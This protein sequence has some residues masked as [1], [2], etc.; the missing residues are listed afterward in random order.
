MAE[1]HKKYA[2]FEELVFENRNKAYGAYDLRKSYSGLLTKAFFIGVALFLAAIILP[3]VY[4]KATE[5]AKEDAGREVEVTLEDANLPEEPPKEEEKEEEIIEK[6]EEKL[7]SLEDL[8]P[9]A[10]TPPVATIQ[11]VVPEPKQ[12]AKNETP[13]P[14]KEDLEGKAISTKTQEGV[15]AIN[16]AP[17]QPKGVEGGR[18]NQE[19]QEGTKVVE[20][21]VDN[22][23]IH[24]AAD[25]EPKFLSG[26]IDGL[27]KM[28]QSNFDTEAVEGEG[29]LTTEVVFVVEPNGTISQVKASGKNSDFNREAERVIRSIRT[30]W[31]PA[32]KGGQKVRYRYRFPLKMRFE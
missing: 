12:D 10:D 20:K 16:N 31:E 8:A 15:A 11:N 28:V 30:K 13:P 25:K 14:P 1:E 9:P 17:A 27:R 2:D 18:G 21:P 6:V 4:M 22:K 29:I 19:K 5:G 3:F 7:Q 23:V 24:D 32:E 26:G